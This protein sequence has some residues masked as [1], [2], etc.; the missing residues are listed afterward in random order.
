MIV[1]RD[2]GA[3]PVESQPTRT[4]RSA[5]A[6]LSRLPV[7]VL[8]RSIQPALQRRLRIRR[9]LLEHHTSAHIRL[10]INDLRLGLE[11]RISRGDFHQHHRPLGERIHHVQIAPVQAQFAHPR[12]D[13]HISLLFDQLGA[14]YERVPGRTAFLLICDGCL[15][16]ETPAD[17]IRR[18]GQAAPELLKH[19]L[20]NLQTPV[21]PPQF[22]SVFAFG[23]GAEQLAPWGFHTKPF[24]LHVPATR[25]AEIV[26]QRRRITADTALRLA[27]YFNT[28]PE[29]W[30]NPQN[31][32][33]LEV[34][35]RA[36]T[37]SEIPRYARPIA[38]AAS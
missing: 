28:N 10:R 12:R 26:H 4:S 33:S 27:R 34:T 7:M 19:T 32:Y 20:T 35:R 24:D 5:P 23:G 16:L 11:E 9:D 22:N 3:A 25:I 37:A 15:R 31:F 17:M 2:C 8:L 30:L 14:R 6:G 38:S 1:R 18:L 13:A 21:L 29:S 36:A